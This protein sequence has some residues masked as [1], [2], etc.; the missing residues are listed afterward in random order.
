MNDIT[1]TTKQPIFVYRMLDL[2]QNRSGIKYFII[3]MII[4]GFFGNCL[5][6]ICTLKSR[7]RKHIYVYIYFIICAD[8][9]CAINYA[10]WPIF[11]DNRPLFRSIH[12]ITYVYKVSIFVDF[13]TNF[14]T[15]T[16]ITLIVFD[17]IFALY[18]PI[19]YRQRISFNRVLKLGIS[20]LLFQTIVTLPYNFKFYFVPYC[21]NPKIQKLV[22]L[23]TEK[24]FLWPKQNPKQWFYA[25]DIAMVIIVYLVPLILV[26][27]GSLILYIGLRLRLRRVNIQQDVPLQISSSPFTTNKVRYVYVSNT[28]HHN[29]PASEPG[30]HKFLYLV[31]AQCISHYCRLALHH[32]FYHINQ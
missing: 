11:V 25:Y 28:N 26:V 23:S 31:Y 5:Y 30:W 12:L 22:E 13:L 18:T 7:F 14:V 10:L 21:Y 32:I 20:L 8:M 9:I 29:F 19:F 2:Y 24:C 16:M 1:N 3:V 15:N 17:R 27:L 4:L 6:L